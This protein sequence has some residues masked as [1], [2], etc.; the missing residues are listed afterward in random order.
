[1]RWLTLSLLVACFAST[2]GAHHPDR[3]NHRIWPRIDLIPPLGNKLPMEYRR[4]FNRP[5]WLGGWIAYKIEPTSQEAMAWHDAAHQRAYK[6]HR[7][8]LEKHFFYPK[9]WE[10]LKIGPRV[11]VL[12]ENKKEEA[13]VT[14]SLQE[15]VRQEEDVLSASDDL[16]NSSELIEQERSI[17]QAEPL[18]IDAPELDP[19]AVVPNSV[20][21]PVER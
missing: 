7:G 14:E 13:A 4:R 20:E 1:M 8:R 10:G 5:T 3:R 16:P 18:S 6:D 15:A 12:E 11:S 17:L 21:S 2:V 9:P 19:P